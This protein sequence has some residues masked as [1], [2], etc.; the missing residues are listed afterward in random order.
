MSKVKIPQDITEA[1]QLVSRIH[2]L[3][4]EIVLENAA[5]EEATKK[6]NEE[7]TA[8]NQPRSK[9]IFRLAQAVNAFAQAR[10]DFLTKSGK[11]KTVKLS[12]GGSLRWRAIPPSV[13]LLADEAVV[14]D[15]L[16]AA[17]LANLVRTKE[18]VNKEAVLGN[19]EAVKNLAGLEIITGK[20]EFEIKPPE[21]PG[22]KP[23]PLKFPV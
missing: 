23:S 3:Q 19:P 10:R 11:A 6:I 21:I 8:E 4:A 17:G 20:E 18:T 16:K 14:V 22:E 12:I 15:A 5:A 9:E 7:A 1:E 13:N 2:E